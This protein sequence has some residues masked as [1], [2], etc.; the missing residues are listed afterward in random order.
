MYLHKKINFLTIIYVTF[1]LFIISI[2][3][4]LLS[5]SF[6]I[7][8]KISFP[9]LI[10]FILFFSIKPELSILFLILIRPLIDPFTNIRFTEDINLL[11]VFSGLFIVFLIFLFFRYRQFEISPPEIRFYYILLFVSV[12]STI[13]SVNVT[14]SIMFFIR[15]VSLLAIYLL[16]YNIV[17]R[18]KDALRVIKCVIYS[19]IIPIIYGFYQ[20]IA[21]EGIASPGFYR[22]RLNS[23]FTHPNMYAFYLVIIFFSIMYLYY[24]EKHINGKSEMIFK[25]CL[26]VGVLIQLMF[27]Y[28]R[29][30]WIGTMVGLLVVALFIN[31]SRKWILIS[32]LVFIALF[33]TQIVSRILDL[34]NPPTKNYMSSW[35]FRLEIWKALVKNAFIHK[36]FLGY[37]L[38]QS[39]FAAEKYSKFSN[40]PHNDYLRVLIE[41]GLVGL[42]SF[43]LFLAHNLWIL[44][45]KIRIGIYSELNT[46][47]L[48]LFMALLVSS[49]ADNLIYSISVVSYLFV[50]LAVGHKLNFL[51]LNNAKE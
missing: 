2:I 51:N 26:S 41:I 28:S 3:G 31:K 44:Y 33:S 29:G 15:F 48:G 49:F 10:F 5:T 36:P 14:E 16:I 42:I 50:M 24:L 4:L 25:V 18:E 19:S 17:Q 13:N 37:G 46:I 9:L 30:S 35:E 27:T 20:Y 6:P 23:T 7:S 47:L 8:I 11:G 34:I 39:M 1:S 38:G 12:L 22:Y 43:L 40:I 32:S 21:G 45:K